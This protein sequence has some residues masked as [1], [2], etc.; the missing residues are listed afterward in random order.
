MPTCTEPTKHQEAEPEGNLISS[1]APFYSL[2]SCF[3]RNPHLW[4]KSRL[5]YRQIFVFFQPGDKGR[6]WKG[7]TRWEGSALNRTGE[8]T[9]QQGWTT[10]H[11]SSYSVM[12]SLYF[13][14]HQISSLVSLNTA[15]TIFLHLSLFL[16]SLTFSPKSDVGFNLCSSFESYSFL[17]RTQS[18][19]SWTLA[20]ND[21][22]TLAHPIQALILLHLYHLD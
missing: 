18:T 14:S 13:C 15:S 3:H 17:H 1:T 21:F 10:R 20:E 4:E 11:N 8:R 16:I 7:K 9:F 19:A 12:S 6:E 22:K 5:S 2:G